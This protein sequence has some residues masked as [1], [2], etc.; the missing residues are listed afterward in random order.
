MYSTV[1]RVFPTLLCLPPY[2]LAYVYFVGPELQSLLAAITSEISAMVVDASLGI[3]FVYLM[4]QVNRTVSKTLWQ[5]FYFDGEKAMPTTRMLL[6][7][8]NDLSD[9]YKMQL[10][11][12]MENDFGVDL[13]TPEEESEDILAARKRVS[14]V[15]ARVRDRVGSGRLLLQ[16]NMEYG[17]VRNL[18]GGCT[19]SAPT[20]LLLAFLLPSGQSNVAAILAGLLAVIYTLPLLFSKWI[21]H[22]YGD[23]YA[24]VLFREYLNAD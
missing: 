3:V 9:E 12:Q 7:S 16:H 21:M 24:K 8:S 17:F 4:S 1:A 10:R 14:E 11:S 22:H 19:L 15:I 23:A 2:A 20:A 6:S 5:K 13:P 18:I